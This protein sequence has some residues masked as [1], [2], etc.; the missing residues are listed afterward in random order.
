MTTPAQLVY[1]NTDLI[2]LILSYNR[3][4][5]C[6]CIGYK[7]KN[8][9]HIQHFFI[10]FYDAFCLQQWQTLHS[11]CKI[12]LDHTQHYNDKIIFRKRNEIVWNGSA[13][14]PFCKQEEKH[15]KKWKDKKGPNRNILL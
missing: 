13:R 9:N 7:N 2:R 5:A 10:N 15:K 4:T 1:F 8:K 14:T 6:G 12:C 11:I 3:C